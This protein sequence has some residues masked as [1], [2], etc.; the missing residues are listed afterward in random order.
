[1][2]SDSC[3]SKGGTA[4]VVLSLIPQSTRAAEL[5]LRLKHVLGK[6]FALKMS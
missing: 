6:A 3:S 5:N 1:M 4:I 2:R